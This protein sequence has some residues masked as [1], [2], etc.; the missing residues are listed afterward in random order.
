MVKVVSVKFNPHGKAYYFDPTSIDVHS[1]DT[2]IVETSKGLDI[3][4]CAFGE[5]YVA[6]ES[7]IP[8]L[9][10]VIRIAT[11]DDLRIAKTNKEREKEA[12]AICKDKIEAHKLDMKLVDVECGFEGSKILFFF[13]A[14]GRVDFRDLVKDLAAVFRTRIELRQIGVRDETKM[15]GGLG[16]C[17]RPYCC[18]QFLN[19]FQPVSTKMAKTQSMSLNPTKI[20]G[21]CGRLMCCLRYEQ[22][23]YEDLVKKIPKTGSFVQTS[24]GYGVV[25]SA[26]VL[27][28]KVKVCLDSGGEQEFKILDAEDVATVPGGRPKPGEPLPQVLVERVKIEEVSEEPVAED[29]WQAPSLFAEQTDGSSQQK[30][31]GEVKAPSQYQS[32]R[33]ENRGEEQR[34]QRPGNGGGRGYPRQNNAKP[35][36][37][38]GSAPAQ[39]SAPNGG[40]RPQ[41]TPK[42][43][44]SEGENPNKPKDNQK[45]QN[46]YRKH[47]Y[48]KPKP[49]NDGQGNG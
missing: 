22:E 8:P 33:P 11:E 31:A 34:W 29:T 14:D 42:P 3:G 37:N 10:P 16:I 9:R 35:M 40:Q 21:S 36:D 43:Q 24:S 45:N 30:T 5:H 32:G 23:A 27:R 49:R 12:F 7:I 13:T 17:G 2:L 46:H 38:R 48:N 4:N 18:N 39:Q 19:D 25:L 41:N 6:D 44:P 20:S 15:L 28:Q 1:G 26:N 47:H